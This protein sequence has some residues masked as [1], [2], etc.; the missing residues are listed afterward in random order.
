MKRLF[1]IL[2]LLTVSIV[3]IGCEEKETLR[4]VSMFGGN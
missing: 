1:S 2:I 3:L 4:T